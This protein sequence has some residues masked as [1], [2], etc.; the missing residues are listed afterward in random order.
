MTFDTNQHI[1]CFYSPNKYHASSFV[2]EYN[3][4]KDREDES[5]KK[6]RK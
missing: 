1:S 4:K 6:N 3:L 2:A 5:L